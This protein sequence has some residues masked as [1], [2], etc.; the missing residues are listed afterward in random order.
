MTQDFETDYANPTAPNDGE[1]R[2]AVHFQIQKVGAGDFQEINGSSDYTQASC[3]VAS[4]SSKASITDSPTPS[5]AV[6]TYY[7]D[8]SFDAFNANGPIPSGD[9]IV[10]AYVTDAGSDWGGGNTGIPRDSNMVTWEV[11]VNEYQS[12]PVIQPQNFATGSIASNE[13]YI[14]TTTDGAGCTPSATVL[15]S[16]SAAIDEGEYIVLHTVVKDLER[17]HLN[18]SVEMEN[19]AGSASSGIG[20]FPCVAFSNCD[21]DKWSS[22]L[23]L[24]GRSHALKYL[25]GPMTLA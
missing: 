11:T 19:F 15:S 8:L 18:V 6:T 17:D 1:D 5:G 25:N 12:A 3:S 2:S 13:S 10:R 20:L 16:G 24:C 7:C 21:S 14:T 9:Y 22:R 23:S 4:G